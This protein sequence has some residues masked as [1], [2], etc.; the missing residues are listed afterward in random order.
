M[1]PTCAPIEM[2]CCFGAAPELVAQFDDRVE[3]FPLLVGP[4][5]GVVDDEKPGCS[6]KPTWKNP[7]C[8]AAAVCSPCLL[9]LLYLL[10]LAPMYLFAQQDFQAWSLQY[11]NSVLSQ[12][13]LPP[14]ALVDSL[15]VGRSGFFIQNEDKYGSNFCAAGMVWLSSFSDVASAL[16]GPQART[17][18][19]GEH[20]MRYD[21]LPDVS[22]SR[23]VFLLSLSDVGAGGTGDHEAFRKGFI[24]TLLAHP[25]VETRRTDA[26]ALAL[27]E[28]LAKDY[29]K[30]PH[31]NF[32]EAF[33]ASTNPAEGLYAFVNKYC[34]YVMF[35]IDPHAEDIQQIL[36][37][38]F[39]G[40]DQIGSYILPYA[41]VMNSV[42]A[43][44]KVAAVYRAS[45][46]F[47]N[48]KE[49]DPKYLRMTKHE[50]ATL[51]A[52]IMRIAGVQG[53]QQ[54]ARIVLGAF[55]LPLFPDVDERFD[56][57]TV[58]DKLNL[59]SSEQ[60]QSYIL[61]CL[62]LDG[63]VSV[64]HHVAT[65]E[66]SV[67]I[68][69]HKY[70]YPKGTKIAIPLALGNIDK[71]FWGSDAHKFNMSRPH[72]ASHSLSFNSVGDQYGR[73]E[74]PAKAFLMKTLTTM[75]QKLGA[76]RRKS[77]SE[78]GAQAFL[79]CGLNAVAALRLGRSKVA[80]V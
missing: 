68:A 7:L 75:V 23:N 17:Y 24:D 33:W 27:I 36:N 41:W 80:P 50:L 5:L 11:P 57:R 66:L 20:P 71:K 64:G 30:L 15:Y 35:G 63:P 13:F 62:R 48:F 40:S 37:G 43:M 46:A 4:P 49:N 38:L 76:V 53:F 61:E 32:G 29:D 67:L 9:L 8:K 47:A 51:S 73:R 70:V 21:R 34:H 1:A 54:A 45:P 77:T 12:V 42:E 16:E 69:G 18:H 39:F 22:N 55:K 14:I 79:G 2:H 6:C 58:W 59:K 78:A 28:E 31:G 52:A 19:L 56:Q 26:T 25:D 44:D 74:C 60:A 72:L 10:I 65:E 3:N